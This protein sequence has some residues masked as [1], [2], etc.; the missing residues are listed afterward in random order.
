MNKN[1]KLTIIDIARLTGFSKSTVS[2]VLRNESYVSKKTK[3]KII[4]I[5]K[6]TGFFP[7][8]VARKLV[9]GKPLDSIGLIV[10]DIS[11]PFFSEIASGAEMEAKK[12]SISIIFLNTNYDKDLERRDIDILIKNRVMGILLAT[13]TTKDGNVLYLEE[14]GFPYVLLTRK[15]SGLNSNIV[16]VD[17][18]KASKNAVEYLVKKG[19]ERIAHFSS[20]EKV[21]GII[22]RE[23][24]YLD[25][26][27]KNG[28]SI[29]K[30]LILYTD[31]TIDGGYNVARDLINKR[32]ELRPTAIFCTNDMIAIGALEFFNQVGIKVPEN[33]SV[34]GYDDIPYSSLRMINLTTVKQ[35]M[36]EMGIKAVQLLLKIINANNP[37][38]IQYILKSKLVERGT[39]SDNTQVFI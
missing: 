30:E 3:D 27:K 39:V 18:F 1:R 5:I 2:K 17:H 34:I 25:A 26:L 11:N 14:I 28:I 16:S 6:E 29:N 38:P 15:V 37:K 22:Q 7:N 13:P 31:L 35:P 8:E 19:H 20:N 4:K 21:Y 10:S 24:G 23:K 12:N 33:M 9:T 32:K 36:I